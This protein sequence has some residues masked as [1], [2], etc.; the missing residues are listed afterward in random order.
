MSRAEPDQPI[1]AREQASHGI[2]CDNCGAKWRLPPTWKGPTANCQRCG[3]SIDAQVQLDANASSRQNPAAVRPAQNRTRGP[4]AANAT[5]PATRSS[6]TTATRSAPAAIGGDSGPRDSG[7]A[8]GPRD[9]R[10][11]SGSPLPWIF[12]G[13][14]LCVLGAIAFVAAR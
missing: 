12:A 3:C 10:R 8:H 4:A 14:A 11:G 9:E 7:R 2:V 6:A 5:R 13:C 1:D